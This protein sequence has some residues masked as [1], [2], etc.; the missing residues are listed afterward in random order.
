M[1]HGSRSAIS[2]T[3]TSSNSIKA[4]YRLGKIP[5][6]ENGQPLVPVGPFIGFPC[7]TQAAYFGEMGTWMRGDPGNEKDAYRKP[8]NFL[9]KKIERDSSL[10]TIFLRKES[11]DG[12]KRAMHFQQSTTSDFLMGIVHLG[13]K[14]HSMM[15]K[16][17]M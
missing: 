15:L 11:C 6:V 1:L 12:L 13:C 4:A 5:I 3:R 16:P 7:M 9:E 2:H 14:K 8:P 10:L 17:G